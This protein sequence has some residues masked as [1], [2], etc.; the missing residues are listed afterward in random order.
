MPLLSTRGGLSS[1]GFGQ[2]NG[3]KPVTLQ[4]YTFPAGSSV[5][6]VPT[7]TNN[8]ISMVGAGA[9]GS[10][11]SNYIYYGHFWVTYLNDDGNATGNTPITYDECKAQ[12]IAVY[13]AMLAL[14]DGAQ[15]YYTS[16]RYFITPNN[17]AIVYSGQQYTSAIAKGTVTRDTSF[18]YLT[19]PVTYT[20]TTGF[21]YY[22][23]QGTQVNDPGSIGANTTGFGKTFVGGSYGPSSTT[24]YSNVAVVPNQTYVINNNKS[25]TITYYA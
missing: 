6:T 12:Q 17:K 11:P 3:G 20:G 25:L 22:I 23:S 18:D 1:R 10:A 15:M 4:T 7:T 16:T 21:G 9:D 24:T 5:F 13:N 14:P 2:L 8:L 19:G